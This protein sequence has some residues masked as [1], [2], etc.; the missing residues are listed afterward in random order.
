MGQAGEIEEVWLLL[1]L[2]SVVSSTRRKKRRRSC[3]RRGRKDR[4]DVG[5]GVDELGL[6]LLT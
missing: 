6:L 1:L 4:V 3:R 2:T 5:D